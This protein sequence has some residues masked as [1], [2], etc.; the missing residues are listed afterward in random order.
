MYN[1]FTINVTRLMVVEYLSKPVIKIL[2][3]LSGKPAHIR[4]ISD[5]LDMSNTT[6][7]NA[8]L[9]LMKLGLIEE[10]RENVKRVI[11]LTNKGEKVA[12]KLMEIEQ[13]LSESS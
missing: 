8:L 1:S 13:I 5:E 10:K 3:Y 4:S 7:Y 2:L 11:S 6:V 12:K 9:T